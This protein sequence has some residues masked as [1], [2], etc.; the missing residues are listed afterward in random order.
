MGVSSL[1]E[2]VKYNSN[3][4][5]ERWNDKNDSTTLLLSKNEFWAGLCDT[6][7]PLQRGSTH[8]RSLENKRGQSLNISMI[9]TAIE[10]ADLKNKMH[11][12]FTI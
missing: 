9:M 7:N 10:L 2:P 11:H 1:Y 12:T 3:G 4:W 8:V 6:P 5:Y